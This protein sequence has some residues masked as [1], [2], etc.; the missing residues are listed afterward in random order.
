MACWKLEIKR[1][2]VRKR[3]P[4]GCLGGTE[5]EAKPEGCPPKPLTTRTTGG[6][7]SDYQGALGAHKPARI[8]LKGNAAS[9]RASFPVVLPAQTLQENCPGQ[10]GAVVKV[11]EAAI[12]PQRCQQGCVTPGWHEVSQVALLSSGHG[13]GRQLMLMTSGHRPFHSPRKCL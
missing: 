5:V 11:A 2:A 3:Q 8:G 4:D 9:G 6:Q 10:W 1:W 12:R 13:R 7:F